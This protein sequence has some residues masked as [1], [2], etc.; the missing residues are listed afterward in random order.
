MLANRIDLMNEVLH[1][2][3]AKLSK[4]LFNDGVVCNGN[5]LFSDFAMTTFVDQLTH[6]LQI[7]ITKTT[8]IDLIFKTLAFGMCQV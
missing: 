2:N 6:T 1:T 7:G 3:Y 8:M 5:A 4:L